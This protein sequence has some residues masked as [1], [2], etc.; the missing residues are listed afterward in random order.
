[1][2]RAPTYLAKLRVVGGGP[3]FVRVGVRDV[4]YSETALDTW[5]AS[6]ISRPLRSTSEAA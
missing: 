5:A 3:V 2:E 1:V 4:A 6:L